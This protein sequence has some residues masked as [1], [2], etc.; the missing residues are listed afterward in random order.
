[1]GLYVAQSSTDSLVYLRKIQQNGIRVADAT[2]EHIS[3]SIDD[4]LVTIRSVSASNAD[5][6]GAAIEVMIEPNSD[7][8]NPILALSTTT[9]IT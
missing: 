5:N 6:D 7:G 1:M 8:T 3:A 9:A 4:G 2:T